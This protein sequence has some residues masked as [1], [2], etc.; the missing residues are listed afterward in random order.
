MTLPAEKCGWGALA[1]PFAATTPKGVQ[2]RK[3]T[4]ISSVKLI[5]SHNSEIAAATP[6][7]YLPSTPAFTGF[8]ATDVNVNGDSI[9]TSHHD[10][11]TVN[12]VNTIAAD[13]NM[14]LGMKNNLP[15]FIKTE[16]ETQIASFSVLILMPR[17]LK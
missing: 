14:T 3:I 15:Y 17:S 12:T 6:F 10:S 8:E 11:I 9:Y 1:L 16:A 4:G 2:V 13:R 7:V 5:H